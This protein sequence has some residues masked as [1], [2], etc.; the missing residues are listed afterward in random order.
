MNKGNAARIFNL[1]AKGQISVGRDADLTL[2]DLH[3]AR[4]VQASALQ[5]VADYSLLEGLSLRGW[6][7]HVVLRG[8]VVMSAGQI[9]SQ[10]GYGQF[11]RRTS[12]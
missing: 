12:A 10:P 1:P 5:S 7:T 6:P 4:T 2:I 9:T 3:E 11:L 8:Q